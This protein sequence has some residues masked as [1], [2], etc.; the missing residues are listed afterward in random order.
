MAER[1]N[2]IVQKHGNELHE[3]SDHI[4]AQV[5]KAHVKSDIL[6]YVEDNETQRQVRDKKIQDKINNIIN[7]RRGTF[8]NYTKNLF[9]KLSRRST[10]RSIKRL[11]DTPI[12]KSSQKP[13]VADPIEKYKKIHP[14]IESIADLSEERHIISD[15]FVD[16]NNDNCY[17][18]PLKDIV[19]PS[20]DRRII[21][22][23]SNCKLIEE[24]RRNNKEYAYEFGWA[25]NLHAAGNKQI[26]EVVYKFLNSIFVNEARHI[27]KLLKTPSTM[28]LMIIDRQ[29][30]LSDKITESSVVSLIMFGVD[31]MLGTCI[32]F[33]GTILDFNGMSF[34]PFLLHNAQIF[35]K[36]AIQRLSKNILK[37][38]ITTVLMCMRGLS[39]YYNRL[40]FTI[41]DNSDFLPQ[42]NFSGAGV[43]FEIELWHDSNRNDMVIMKT[44]SMCPRMV[45]HLSYFRADVESFVFEDR[46]SNTWLDIIQYEKLRRYFDD[47]FK[48][49]IKDRQYMQINTYLEMFYE[50]SSSKQNFFERFYNTAFMIPVGDV[51][52]SG[53]AIYKLSNLSPTTETVEFSHLFTEA[54]NA[55]QIVLFLQDISNDEYSDQ[56]CWLKVQC[57]HCKKHV[58]IKK[59]SN[60][61]FDLFLS[62]V[63][64]SVW[65]IHVFSLKPIDGND[66]YNANTNWSVCTKR[67]G[68]IFNKLKSAYHKDTQM[69][70]ETVNMAYKKSLMGLFALWEVLSSNLYDYFDAIC[71]VCYLT[72]KHMAIEEN[73]RSSGRTYVERSR[74][75]LKT[76]APASRLSSRQLKEKEN[77]QNRQRRKRERMI[78]LDRHEAEKEWKDI[79]YDD[80]ETQLRFRHIE[81][82]DVATAEVLNEVSEDHIQE[83]QDALNNKK[84]KRNKT[85]NNEDHNFNHYLMYEINGNSPHVVDEE[86]FVD[87]DGSNTSEP[88]Q[89]TRRV[90]AETLKKC[91]DLPNQMHYLSETDLRLIKKHVSTV[92]VGVSIKRIKR[93]VE[94]PQDQL[95]E[96]VNFEGHIS[97][98]K[99][100]YIGYDI[101]N[102]HHRL[103]E[104]WVEL[105]F[106]ES[107]PAVYKTIKNLAAG[108][109]YTLPAGSSQNT[110]DKDYLNDLI[111]RNAIMVTGPEIKHKQ[112]KEYSCIAH[113]L[114]S[115]LSY[116]R[117]ESVADRLINYYKDLTSGD[118]EVLFSMKDALR[119]TAENYG[120]KKSE[121]KWKGTIKKIKKPN[122]MEILKCNRENTFYHCVLN[123]NHAVALFENWIFDPT[124]DNAI[125]RDEKHLRFSSER[126]DSE[127]TENVIVLCYKYS[128]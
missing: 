100:A 69:T 26:Q 47:E 55:L 2:I 123:N 103:S 108:K 37:N 104:D 127:S 67:K 62:T 13:M 21:V 49:L 102:F 86:W 24:E 124:L 97:T 35:G 63:V 7:R 73:A 36:K 118:S 34:G 91:V 94:K 92:K 18:I 25:F 3:L 38:N 111:S 70:E 77:I 68:I 42:G 82:V 109:E 96:V 45:N 64:T 95:E 22:H 61:A 110:S 112:R 43:R 16:S 120:R 117:H 51:Y 23:A 105:N 87:N 11:V 80:L 6:Q 65:F 115:V 121:K 50:Q 72:E 29:S 30:T 15:Y 83:E 78:K 114:A 10:S 128:F 122:T 41:C 79:F 1:R 4:N 66:W 81:Y 107:H 56:E 20:I 106:K 74:E 119:V 58:F 99:L 126:Y 39:F 98:S 90:S 85:T 31:D 33:I 59:P 12:V 17:S 19:L 27:R 9:E 60:N 76:I 89:E 84:G 116:I 5:C 53:L 101:K 46:S 32:D 44:E 54:M 48:Q 40:G 125:P 75:L 88:R 57:E 93:V 8:T 14:K 28:V 52:R 113:S 71:K